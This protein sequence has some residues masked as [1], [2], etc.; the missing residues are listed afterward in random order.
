MLERV[1]SR[2]ALAVLLYHRI[3]KPEGHR[4]DA[5]V[6]EATPEQFDAQMA[7]LKKRHSVLDPDE[8]TDV[9][10]NP[11]KLRHLRVAITFDDAYRD[12]YDHAFPIL[13]SHGLRATF[14]APTRYL[15]TRRIPWWDQIAWA[16]RNARKS[17]LRLTYPAELVARVDERDPEPAIRAVIRAYTRGGPEVDLARYLAAV[18]EACE[19]RLPDEVDDRQFMSW[20]EAREMERAGMAIGSHTHS[21]GILANMSAADQKRECEESRSRLKEGSLSAETLAYPVGN[22]RTFSPTTVRCAREAG[23]R[24]AFSNYGGINVPDRMDP[25][26]VRRIGMSLDVDVPELRMK[27][28]L[29]GLAGRELW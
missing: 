16:V 24:C 26:D 14:F 7:M 1:G 15:G 8:L 20:E 4:Y 10:T 3:L 25:F 11:R 23:Y 6:I 21:H 9:V 5:G 18:E 27:L 19:L 28:V 29:S 12:N 2:P 13:A 22:R 17:E